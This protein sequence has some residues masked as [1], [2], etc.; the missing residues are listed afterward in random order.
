MKTRLYS[1]VKVMTA[2]VERSR[3]VVDDKLIRLSLLRVRGAL[4]RCSSFLLP[5]EVLR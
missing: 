4:T 5:P 3:L 1:S 2:R